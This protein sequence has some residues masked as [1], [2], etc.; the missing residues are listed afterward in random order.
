[1][2]E[3]P[4]L[5]PTPVEVAPPPGRGQHGYYH[6]ANGWVVVA[7]TTPS[8]KADYE[9]KKH[10]FLPQYGEFVP[11]TADPRAN[12]KGADDKGM[13]WNSALEPWR[14]IFQRDGAKEFPVDQIIAYRWHI[15]PPYKEVTF[16]QLEGIDITDY[17]CPECDK[18][19]FSSPNPQEAA[20]QLRTHLTSAISESHKYS[21]TDLRELGKEWGIDFDT[22][23]VG[24][25]ASLSLES[26]QEPE[27]T[28]DPVRMQKVD[29]LKKARQAKKEKREAS[30]P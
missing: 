25:R 2:T 17:P 5:Y 10:V 28:P 12:P 24:K 6:K 11:D 9:Y 27:G 1:M 30:R 13:P 19:I 3:A 8:N 23:R 22:A 15:R 20:R 7:A 18:G 26:G 14:L 29:A 16:P 21:A 4:T